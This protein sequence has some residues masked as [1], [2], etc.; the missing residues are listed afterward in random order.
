M[1]STG[2][3]KKLGFSI[4]VAVLLIVSVFLFD[5]FL[6]PA[7]LFSEWIADRRS[8]EEKVLSALRAPEVQKKFEE[9]IAVLEKHS[10]EVRRKFEKDISVLENNSAETRKEFEKEII[11]MKKSSE[12]DRESLRNRISI[13]EKYSSYV[14]SDAIYNIIKKGDSRGP[15]V[16]LGGLLG[17][18]DNIFVSGEKV[19]FMLL[20]TFEHKKAIRV[21][22]DR[23]VITIERVVLSSDVVLRIDIDGA[24]YRQYDISSERWTKIADFGGIS[25]LSIVDKSERPYAT[26]TMQLR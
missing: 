21:C 24:S 7:G 3:H 15:F 19:F 26:V 25:L 12:Y 17:Y 22:N 16:E 18:C 2:G 4:F 9:E 23:I 20:A 14:P 8:P 1:E 13:L 11:S 6:I 5:K 10:D